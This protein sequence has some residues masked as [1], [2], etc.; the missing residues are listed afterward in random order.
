MDPITKSALENH[1]KWKAR[2][3]NN[4]PILSVDYFLL[5]THSH[6]ICPSTD[7]TIKLS[8]GCCI[9][10]VPPLHSKSGQHL[11][12][13]VYIFENPIPIQLHMQKF[14]M[15][16]WTTDPRSRFLQTIENTPS[17][18]LFLIFW[19]KTSHKIIQLVTFFPIWYVLLKLWSL[20]VCFAS[21]KCFLIKILILQWFLS[22][23]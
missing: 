2:K 1:Q 9:I 21:L 18:A 22:I 20:S 7:L 15:F 13:K 14:R 5:V 4:N 3:H 23:F 8:T 16:P 17:C 10:S 11:S 12:K 19:Y 6:R